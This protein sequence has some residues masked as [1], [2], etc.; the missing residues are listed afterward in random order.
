MQIAIGRIIAA[1]IVMLVWC[2]N[3]GLAAVPGNTLNE[4]CGS[5]G[6]S[7]E[8]ACLVFLHGY[9]EGYYIATLIKEIER[10]GGTK[11]EEICL[12]DGWTIKQVQL[13]VRKYLAQNPEELHI[14]AGRIVLWALTKA[15]P[16]R[17]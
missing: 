1:L 12:P 2:P 14:D 6:G 13:V 15:F 3:A 5:K 10:R 8:V 7:S 9:I 11:E 16:C 17:K 4:W